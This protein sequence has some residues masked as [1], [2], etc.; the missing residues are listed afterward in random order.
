M[1]RT[2]SKLFSSSGRRKS[3]EE[4]AKNAETVNF[5]TYKCGHVIPLRTKQ[6]PDPANDD[7]RTCA[8]QT[9]FEKV[10]MVRRMSRVRED[11]LQQAIDMSRDI[12]Q[13]LGVE[14]ERSA[15]PENNPQDVDHGKVSDGDDEVSKFMDLQR[16]Q[17][18]KQ[19]YDLQFVAAE[20]ITNLFAEWK[21]KWGEPTENEVH[22]WTIESEA[23]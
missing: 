21:T 12:L 15:P 14:E 6:Q 23:R 13:E 2:L 18:M 7:C 22:W 19:L 8:W 1:F 9:L 11:E 5:P 10:K 4:M 16:E 20:K 17:W 3:D